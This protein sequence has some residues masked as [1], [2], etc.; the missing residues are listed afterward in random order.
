MI[1]AVSKW[2]ISVLSCVLLLAISVCVTMR[3]RHLLEELIRGSSLPVMMVS[4]FT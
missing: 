4:H 3:F 1:H 2:L